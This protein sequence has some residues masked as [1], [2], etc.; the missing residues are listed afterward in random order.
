M[1]R[2]LIFSILFCST[3][4][5]AQTYP[6]LKQ[7]TLE[8]GLTVYLWEDKNQPDVSGRI[9]VRAGSIDEPAEYSGLAHYLEHMLFKGTTKIGAL[10]WGKEKPLYDNIIRMYDEYSTSI[11]PVLRDTLMKKINRESLESAK[12]TITSDFS[13]LIEGMGGEG[14][15]AGTSYDQTVYL[16]NFPS[17]Q[18]EK[19]LDVYSE[20][21]I[22]PVF[23]SFQAELE[24]VFEEYNMYQDSRNTHVRN[25]LF[26]NLYPTHPYGRDIIGKAEHLKN[27]RLS[28][29]IE[30]YQKWYVP[31]NMAL[32]LVGNFDSEQIIPL[33]KSKFGRLE[34]KALPD[35]VVYPPASFAGN[36]K[37]TAKL[38]YSPQIFW[39]YKGVKKGDKD[40][41]LLDVCTQILSNSM[42]TGL[43]DKLMLNG[44]IN[45]AGA[46]NDMRRDDGRLLVIAVPYYDI[47]QRVYES[48]KATEKLV[49]TEVDKLKNGNIEDWLIASVKN[50]LLRQYDLVMETPSAKTEVL[51]EL[52]TYNL[53]TSEFFSMNDRI[54]AV[55]KEDIQ[56]IAKQYFSGDYMTVSIEEGNPKKEKLRKPEIKA[57]DQAK[58]QKTEYAQIVQKM[59]IGIVAEKFNNFDDVKSTKLYDKINLFCTENKQN[60]IFTLTIRYKVGTR[61]MPKLEYAVDLMNS[62][63]IMPS[64]DAQAVRRQFSELNTRCNYSVS[65]DYFV[66]SLMGDEKN[67]A[68]ACKLMTRQ[69]LMPRLDDKQLDRVKGNTIQSRLSVEKNDLEMISDALYDYSIY[70]DSS[71]YIDRLKMMQ[72]YY[73]K[74]S[75]LT[76]EIIRATDY[77]A[78]IHYVGK[79]GLQE[80]AEVL[81]ANLPLKEGV[82]SGVSPMMKDRITYDKPTI[83]FLPNSDAQQAKIYFYINGS[84]YKIE[85]KVA[86]DAFFQYFSG[87]FNGLVMNVIRENNSMAYTAYGAFVTPPIANKKAY[88]KGY[89]GTQGDKVADAIDLYMK[90][91]TDMPLYP[92]RIDNI[93]TYLHQS[94]LTNKPSFRRES[95]AFNAWKLL[96]Y[97][98]DPAKVNMAKIDALTFD[99]IVAFYNKEIKGKPVTIVIMGDPKTINLNQIQTNQGKVTKLR[100]SKLFSAEE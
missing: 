35:R 6:G 52:F 85:D 22:N 76:G 48:D 95:Q 88:F 86:Y 42:Q 65:E 60:D 84:E 28:K 24:N 3:F 1:R 74:I 8:N 46:Q 50:N 87:G 97:A 47:N 15:N 19:W 98:E 80:V 16:N 94:S 91:L 7:F 26:S 9:V 66:I 44:D 29:L 5:A 67:L 75:E 71:N 36:P 2:I 62:A 14:L 49:M 56:R 33:I 23:R 58:N 61:K 59:P 43:L 34:N 32:V 89:V 11:D 53:P 12:Y 25:F 18:M 51:T 17:F 38:S 39:G 20:R 78:D 45:Y 63:G 93:K 70:K 21:L 96:G 90:L 69:T 57:L 13:N 64:S 31:G 10:N 72:V 92:D 77:E 37:F 82:K 27:P 54:H 4:L 99:Q 73:L 30:F 79:K 100:T 83:Y 81:K 40:E 68:E 41:L 55:T